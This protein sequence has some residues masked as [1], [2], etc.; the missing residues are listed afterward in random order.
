[1]EYSAKAIETG[2]G[3]ATAWARIEAG[4][5]YPTDV[6]AGAA[7][8]NFV[9]LFVHDAFLGGD[10]SVSVTVTPQGVPALSFYRSF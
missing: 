8:G 2:F 3:Y 9:S 1:L 4:A 6:L 10:C 5:H 7:L